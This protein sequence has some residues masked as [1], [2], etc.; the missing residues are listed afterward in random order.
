[1]TLSPD[2][3]GTESATPPEA[4]SHSRKRP[5]SKKSS[6]VESKHILPRKIPKLTIVGLGTSVYDWVNHQWANFD[7]NGEVWTINAG[8]A[9]FR[10]DVLWD[11]HTTEWLFRLDDRTIGRALQ[12]RH[13][14]KVHDKPIIMPKTDPE[15]P[16]SVAYPLRKVIE[17]TKSCYFATGI[18]YM[19]AMAYLCDVEELW[20]F[21]CDFSY[22]R[23]TNTHDEQ[24]RACAEYWIGRLVERGTRV[25]HTSK[26]HLM[27]AHKRSKGL[28]YGYHEPIVMDY[29]LTGGRGVFVG[30]D[31]D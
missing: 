3:D 6:I 11:M 20:L 21:G 14:L 5:P 8:A 31:Y 22:A 25:A 7:A 1:M 23:N 27:D 12:R 13:W 19:L 9:V 28:I 29:P 18:A 26:T 24:G 17:G 2:G 16:M 30:P 10:H 15:I 4:R